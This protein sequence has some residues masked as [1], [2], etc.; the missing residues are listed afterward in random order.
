MVFLGLELGD[1]GWKAQANPLSYSGPIGRPLTCGQSYKHFA[2]VNYD[3][4][5]EICAIFQSVQL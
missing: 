2:S 1:K 3:P 4:R 5:V